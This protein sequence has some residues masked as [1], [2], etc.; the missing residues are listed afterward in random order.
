MAESN[1]LGNFCELSNNLCSTM[2]EQPSTK[3]NTSE[4]IWV[5]KADTLALEPPLLG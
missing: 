1:K 2:V 5:N 3:S 4:R